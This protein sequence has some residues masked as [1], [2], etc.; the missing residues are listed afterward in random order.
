MLHPAGFEVTPAVI[1]PVSG[2][3]KPGTPFNH[4]AFLT[5][6]A[7]DAP[8]R[9]LLL[10]SVAC[11]VAY[12]ACMYCMLAATR[13]AGVNKYLGYSE[14]SLACCGPGE[15]REFTMGIDDDERKYSSEELW[16][17]AAQAEQSA[18]RGVDVGSMLGVK[19]L[20]SMFR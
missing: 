18:Q 7:A 17:L 13:V 1:D 2:A 19:G 20:A 3:I 11:F 16:L 5:G 15:G 4:K 6:I 12:L 8:A 10:K 14:P 9:A